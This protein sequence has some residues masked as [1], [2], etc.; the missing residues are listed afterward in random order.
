MPKSIMGNSQAGLV[1]QQQHE[2]EVF[3]QQAQGHAGEGARPVQ[4][5]RREA[6]RRRRASGRFGHGTHRCFSGVRRAVRGTHRCLGGTRRC[7]HGAVRA[8]QQPAQAHHHDQSQHQSQPHPVPAQDE[9]HEHQCGGVEHGVAQPV[10][11]RA[12]GG[13]PRHWRKPVRRAAQQ[14][15]I[16]L[17]T[18]SRLAVETLPMPEP[19]RPALHP[20]R[21]QQRLHGRPQQQSEQERLPDRSPVGDRVVQRRAQRRRRDGAVRAIENGGPDGVCLGGHE[22]AA[23][24]QGDH[25]T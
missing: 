5:H 8:V 25:F 13:R 21:R 23:V 2:N 16:M 17:G 4:Q 6:S 10:G 7:L 12:A 22:S 18:E 14:V 20:V 15:H 1:Y 24:S 19:P 3:G 11:G 9:S